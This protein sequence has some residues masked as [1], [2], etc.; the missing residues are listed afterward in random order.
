MN[1]RKSNLFRPN[2]EFAA[3]PF[4]VGARVGW[5]NILSGNG[6][7]VMKKNLSVLFLSLLISGC[8]SVT[9]EKDRPP[10]P[11]DEDFF[12]IIAWD[13]WC[14][15][16]EGD[17]MP[18]QEIFDGMAECGITVAGFYSPQ[19]LDM[20]DQAGLV[21]YVRDKRGN[22]HDQWDPAAYDHDKAAEEIAELVAEVND[23][24]AVYG[25]YLRDEPSPQ[26]FEMIAD[27]MNI[28]RSLNTGKELYV[29]MLPGNNDQNHFDYLNSFVE[30][31]KPDSLGYDAYCVLESS[32]NQ[33][34]SWLWVNLEAM[35]KVS[36]QHHLPFWAVVLSNAHFN[37]RLPTYQDLCLEVYA[38]LAYGAK[39]I[40]YFT[41]MTP[42]IGNFRQAPIDHLH[43]KTPIWDHLRTINHVILNWAPILNQLESTQVYHIPNSMPDL[44]SDPNEDSILSGVK[45]GSVVVGEFRHKSNNYKYLL[46]V[47]KDLVSS[48]SV[49]PQFRTPPKAVRIVSKW[50]KNLRYDYAFDHSWLAPGDAML[51]EI[52]E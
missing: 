50:N 42:Y 30:T 10:R 31:C 2:S 19:F 35:Y 39:G 36:N 21:T 22:N 3:A 51:L 32:P 12:P 41:Y 11:G 14:G 16:R 5:N 33:M 34:T 40:A 47:N 37:Y 29:N 38:P 7:K 46:I 13:A 6:R 23:H 26:H 48:I 44:F 15:E 17:H 49:E 9:E 8:I 1:H 28:Y 4:R 18:D 27:M 45:G 43:K 25:Y 20:I 52:E 24:P